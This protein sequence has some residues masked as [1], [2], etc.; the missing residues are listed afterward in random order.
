MFLAALEFARLQLTLPRHASKV[1]RLMANFEKRTGKRTTIV[2]GHRTTQRQ[3]EIYA[4]STKGGKGQAYRAAPPGHS[5]H[6][7]G[8]ATDL[9]IIGETAGDAVTDKASMWYGILA[10]EARKVGL[11]AGYDFMGRLPDPYHVEEPESIEALRAEYNAMRLHLLAIVSVAVVAL[12][13][14]FFRP[15]SA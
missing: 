6:Q 15:S 4:D 14:L 12:L 11:K 10:E 7:F 5:K 1:T 2:E 9:N 13:M 8:A 3:A